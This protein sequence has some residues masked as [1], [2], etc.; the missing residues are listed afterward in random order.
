MSVL[1]D[2]LWAY[3]EEASQKPVTKVMRTWTQQLGYPVI[4]VEGKQVCPVCALGAG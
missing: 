1:L 4:T 2:D 3:L